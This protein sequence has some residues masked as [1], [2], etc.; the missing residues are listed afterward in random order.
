[1]QLLKDFYKDS[2]I[3]VSYQSIF[4]TLFCLLIE[5]SQVTFVSSEEISN[6]DHFDFTDGETV[7]NALKQVFYDPPCEPCDCEPQ[8]DFLELPFSQN[9]NHPRRTS[10]ASSVSGNEK[11]VSIVHIVD[12]SFTL[13]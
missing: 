5:C 9:D 1:M 3:Y 10:A 6:V 7:L 13:S 12:F 4:L 8:T 2:P 11:C